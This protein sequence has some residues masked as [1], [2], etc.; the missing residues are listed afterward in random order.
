MPDRPVALAEGVPASRARS[1]HGESPCHVLGRLTRAL[2]RCE[3]ASDQRRLFLQAALEGARATTAI[4]WERGRPETA[5]LIGERKA[6]GAWCAAL[7]NRLLADHLDDDAHVL[8]PRAVQDGPEPNSPVAIALVR[9]SRTPGQWVGVLRFDA[10]EPFGADEVEFLSLARQLLSDHHRHVRLY[11]ELKETVLGLVRSFTTAID[12]KDQYTCGHSERVGRIATR[13]GQ[14]MNLPGAMLSD[15][16]LAGL[17]HDIG[18]I[19]IRD[20][21]LLKEGELTEEERGHI[22]EHPVIG[23]RIVSSIRQLAHLCPGVRNHHER[24]DGQGYP[25]RLAG[26]GIPLLARVLAV[27]DSCDAM[28]ADRPYRRSLPP[29]RIDTTILEGAGKQW[30]PAV[31][32]HFMACRHDLYA[33]CQKGLGQSVCA[34]VE[35]TMGARRDRSSEEFSN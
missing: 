25:D 15:L 34:A 14:E 6:S 8:A 18:K 4:S 35:E 27:A 1:D 12:A 20:S 28:M 7:A 5:E 21:V 26:E 19:G 13:L 29:G 16:Y 33:I 22:R 2:Q 31:V 30:D 3:R 24:Y 9:V 32:G 10:R 11:G 17:L 23:E